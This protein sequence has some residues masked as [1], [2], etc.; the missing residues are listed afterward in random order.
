MNPVC[1][2]FNR[3]LMSELVLFAQPGQVVFVY[4]VF[5]VVRLQARLPSITPFL[6]PISW[7]RLCRALPFMVFCEFP[8]LSPLAFFYLFDNLLLFTYDNRNLAEVP[9][10]LMNRT[11]KGLRTVSKKKIALAIVLAILIIIIVAAIVVDR[12]FAIIVSSPKVSY[13][14]LARP[15]MRAQ[16]VLDVPKAKEIIKK[17]L[18]AGVNVPDWVLPRALPYQAALVANMDFAMS[19]I[20]L[21]LFINDQRLAPV[22]VDQINRL[23]LPAPVDQWFK[24]KMVWNERGRMLRKGIAPVDRAFL[25]K[26]KEIFKSK[27]G[28]AS[29][30]R[31][32]GGHL[33]EAVLDNRDGSAIAI[34][35]TLAATQGVPVLDYA[36]EGYLGVVVP[37]DVIRLQADIANDKTLN[38]H[39]ALE[40][41]PD[42][43]P[44]AIQFLVLG[45]EMGVPPLQAELSKKGITLT[46][47]TTVENNVVK[48][49]YTVPNFDQAIDKL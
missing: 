20:D 2:A 48:G 8:Y 35:G 5:F 23:R 21:T 44:G 39:L 47:K 29:P 16:I 49:D 3:A 28:T 42:T 4:F 7:L 37:I 41:A 36:S 14:T 38:I 40:C 11:Q 30:L 32:E 10:W 34:V 27:S 19:E 12:K 6:V 18:L 22:L 1:P 13:E 33:L 31:L 9:G 17:K 24:D 15:E 43:E 25:M 26:L 46:G 45:L